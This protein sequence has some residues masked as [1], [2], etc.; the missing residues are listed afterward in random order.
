MHRKFALEFVAHS[1][2]ERLVNVYQSSMASVGVATCLYYLA[3]NVDVM[4]K[5]CL[6][7]TMV[8][9]ELVQLGVQHHIIY[10]CLDMLYGYWN[11]AMKVVVH[12][13]LCSLHMHLHFDRLSNDLIN[14]MVYVDYTTMYD[15]FF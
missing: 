9:D 15:Y 7:P 12:R 1:G 10:L 5:V 11:T 13:R 3:Y 6:L 4:E 14:A 2:I 8:L